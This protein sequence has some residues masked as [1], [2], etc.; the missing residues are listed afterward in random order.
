MCVRL[1]HP[2]LG[3]PCVGSPGSVSRVGLQVLKEPPRV[4][5]FTSSSTAC[6]PFL[7]VTG[8]KHS[9]FTEKIKDKTQVPLQYH[10]A[11]SFCGIASSLPPWKCRNCLPNFLPPLRI[12]HSNTYNYLLSDL[13]FNHWLHSV[14]NVWYGQESRKLFG[15]LA[16]FIRMNYVAKINQISVIHQICSGEINNS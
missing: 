4:H 1:I 11:V 2:E 7:L 12:W 5:N 3:S 8:L 9:F 14:S 13:F 6:L 10:S 15:K 16:S